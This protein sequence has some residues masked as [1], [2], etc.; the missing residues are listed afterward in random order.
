[1]GKGKNKSYADALKRAGLAGNVMINKKQI[2]A[3]GGVAKLPVTA[4]EIIEERM[5]LKKNQKIAPKKQISKPVPTPPK[6]NEPDR[7]IHKIEEYSKPT[8]TE[9]QTP[10]WFK[11]DVK[12][13]V[14]VVIP[15]F[16]SRNVIQS[17]ISSWEFSSKFNTEII[18]VSDACPQQSHNVIVGCFDQITPRNKVGKILVLNKNSGFSTACNIG[19]EASNSEFVIFL[20]ADTILTKNWIDN[21]IEPLISKKNIGLVGNLQLNNNGEIDSAGS[22]WV[23]QTRCFEHIGRNI[24]NGKRL[25][26]R[27][28][29]NEAPKDVKDSGYRQMVTGCCIAMKRDLFAEVGKFDIGYRIGYWEDADLCMKVLEKDKKIWFASD[30]IIY[31]KS[32]HSGSGGHPYMY[33]NAKLFYSKWVE[34][35]KILSLLE[36]SKN[37]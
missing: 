13:D 24:Y 28:K 33:D 6:S 15:M 26:K 9:I 31:H 35:N 7:F 21:I 32:G 5:R 34:N 16:R 19:E 25:V 4:K 29:L 8:V 30:S 3:F 12:V 36:R 18:F 23:W 10:E 1:M 37:G 20:N 22:E 17:L 27:M 2:G 11:K 14:S